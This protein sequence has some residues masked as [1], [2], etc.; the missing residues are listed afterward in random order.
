MTLISFFDEDPVDNIGDL[1]YFQPER[2]VFVGPDVVMRKR[3]RRNILNFLKERGMET[4]VIFRSVKPDSL[5]EAVELLREMVMDYPDSIFDVTGGTELMIAAAGIITGNYD[6]PMYQRKGQTNKVLWQY[7]CE[8]EPGQGALSIRES[9]N[10]HSAKV[11]DSD[12]FPRWEITP[13]LGRDVVALWEIA[14]G[15]AAQW[16]NTCDAFAALSDETVGD[17]MLQIAVVSQSGQQA[18]LQINERILLDLMDGGFILDFDGDWGG[19][20]F[21]F[22]DEN[23]LRILTKA[24]NLLELYTCLAADFADDRDVG[25]PLD[26]DGIIQPYGVMDTRNELDVMLTVGITP[27]CISCKNGM[28]EKEDLYELETIANHFG[29]RFSKKVL[30]A[31]YINHN[32]NSRKSLIQRAKDMGITLIADVDKISL[33]EFSAQ[34]REVVKDLLPEAE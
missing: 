17:D 5:E 29:G 12:I 26:W 2:C 33:D 28:C 19:M 11:F 1:V 31:T 22:R 3:R 32:D 4:E 30:V 13:A 14:K 7:G 10:L 25:V 20:S 15:N 6:I 21:R 9:V 27:V 24:G 16:N 34:L 23:I 18:S 8:M